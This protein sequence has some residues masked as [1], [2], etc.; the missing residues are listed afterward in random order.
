MEIAILDPRRPLLSIML[1]YIVV[2]RQ[3]GVLII[4]GTRQ[5][6]PRGNFFEMFKFVK[7]D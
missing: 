3:F 1:L 6:D 5:F 2:L 4:Q 7:T